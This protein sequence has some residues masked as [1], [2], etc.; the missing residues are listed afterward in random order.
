MICH[1]L[2]WWLQLGATAWLAPAQVLLQESLR[3]ILVQLGYHNKLQLPLLKGLA[4]LLQ[5]LSSWFNITLGARQPR[6]H[7]TRTH[8]RTGD[9]AFPCP[10]CQA[11]SPESSSLQLQ[12]ACRGAADGP[13]EGWSLTSR[14]C[15]RH[16]WASR[17]PWCTSL[18]QQAC[19]PLCAQAFA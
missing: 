8:R 6:R 2:T 5:L 13:F 10:L 9:T 3:P 16:A 11:A 12:P 18:G 1:T 14:R 19:S 4:R 17:V 7:C 15:S